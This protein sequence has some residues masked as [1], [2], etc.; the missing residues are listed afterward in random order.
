M[1][2]DTGSDW[3]ANLYRTLDGLQPPCQR[4]SA[5]DLASRPVDWPDLS[6]ETPEQLDY[7]QETFSLREHQQEA[8]DDVINGFKDVDR[9]KLI[10][11]CGTGKT[12]TALRIAEEVAGVGGRVLYLVSSI[13]LFS[14]AMREWAEQQGVPH[15]YIGICSDTKAGKTSED[16]SILE[17]EIPVTTDHA[18]I[19]QALQK[20]D[21]TTMQV[22]FCT[23]HFFC[24][25]HSR[26]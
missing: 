22:V 10:M 14:Q 12:F 24:H 5:A 3:S 20:T 15:R 25:V 1:F 26:K 9:G 4:I 21:D 11:A 16:A 17:L 2:V 13:G 6:L 19:S 8:F 7:Q 23:Y 18:A